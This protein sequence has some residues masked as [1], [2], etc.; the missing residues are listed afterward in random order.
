M[1]L[2]SNRSYHQGN[3]APEFD[4]SSRNGE[5][6]PMWF[7]YTPSPEMDLLGVRLQW[8]GLLLLLGLILSANVIKW[9]S[10][11][12]KMNLSSSV[13]GSS[14]TWMTLFALGGGRIGYALFY[15]FNMFFQFRGDFPFW[16]MFAL[17]EGG[18]SFHGCILG[19][20]LGS[21]FLVF[22][23]ELNQAY[24]L[25]VAALVAPLILIFTRLGSFLS[26]E[27][28]G[29]AAPAGF[30]WALRFPSEVLFWGVVSPEK[31]SQAGFSSGSEM[32]AA[33]HQN[34]VAFLAQYGNLLEGRHPVALYSAL[35]EGLLVFLI[36]F[37]IWKSPRRPGVVLSSY[38][39]LAGLAGLVLSPL[40]WSIF[41]R[42]QMF[43]SLS[44]TQWLHLIMVIWSVVFYM[45][46]ARSRT[47]ILPGWGIGANI[48]IHRRL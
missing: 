7:D 38:F 45:L 40:H 6:L 5:N 9:L 15:D 31:L 27:M 10:R 41:Q 17:G 47:R 22:R 23:H 4:S 12:Q 26:G 37:F 32:L 11:R 24:V 35:V 33:Y 30:Q 39:F 14:M 44:T 20:V 36:L 34:P 42:P 25:D 18:F 3:I 21:V 48:K 16:G 29:S 13:I 28:P 2:L 1:T 43:L 8:G 19:A 46:W